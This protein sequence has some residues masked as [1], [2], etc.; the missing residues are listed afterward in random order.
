MMKKALA[1]ALLLLFLTACADSGVNETG[2]VPSFAEN[3]TVQSAVAYDESSAPASPGDTDTAASAV[4]EPSGITSSKPLSSAVSSKNT[5]SKAASSKSNSSKAASSAASSKSASSKEISSA[6]ETSKS[7]S[8]K[9]SSAASKAVSSAA[10]SSAVSSQSEQTEQETQPEEN[11]QQSEETQLVEQ[12]TIIYFDEFPIVN[13]GEIEAPPPSPDG[14]SEA[15]LELINAERE[16][17]GCDPLVLERRLC[18]AADKRSQE[19]P[20]LF[21]HQRPDG[22]DWFTVF[23]EVGAG[24]GVCA[25]NI[26]EGQKTPEEAVAYWMTSEVHR[27]SILDPRFKRMGVGHYHID[28]DIYGE[29]WV[30][31][32][33]D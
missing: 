21:E 33:S 30:Q 1:A 12:E 32:F 9:A 14:S 18:E 3:S 4:S 24:Y 31:E 22:A 13:S 5:S 29:Y 20:S 6:G 2:G 8:S 23:S 16:K 7:A 10:E 27:N 28:G 11:T 26:A 17:A 19:I 25:E 15:V